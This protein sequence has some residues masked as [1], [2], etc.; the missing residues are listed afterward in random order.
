MITSD[1]LQQCLPQANPQN[2]AKYIDPLN[3]AMD[4][5]EINTN[6]R[7]AAF[8]AEIGDE[9]EYLN[10]V[11]E[12]LNYS[13]QGLLKIFPSHFTPDL[14]I[15]YNRNPEAIANRVYANRMENGD[16]S[17]G[18]GWAFRGRGLIQ[19]TGRNN[20]N[21]ISQGLNA[22][23]I[24]QPE[25]LET[26]EGACRSAG[27]YWKSRGLN[28]LADSGNIT[29]IS[30]IINGGSIGLATRIQLYQKAIVVLNT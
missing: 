30:K 25:Y 6:N 15:Q 7:I 27:W 24:S 20:Y 28:E 26:P 23:V 22:D 11:S 21:A 18:D 2:V 13:S 29:Q 1:Q 8:I 16:E 10:C 4:E 9:S 19:L 14:A 17:S 12:N 3:A 5:F